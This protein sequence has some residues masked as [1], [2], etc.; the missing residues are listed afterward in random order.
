MIRFVI[1]IL[2]I[3]FFEMGVGLWA[4][5]KPAFWSVC[6]SINKVPLTRLQ[7]DYF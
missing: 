1:R 4:I 2:A 6:F 7:Y 3:I 5:P